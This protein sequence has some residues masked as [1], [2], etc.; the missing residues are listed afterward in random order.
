MITDEK[1]E[2]IPF[3]DGHV[4]ILAEA[5]GLCASDA[6]LEHET[7]VFPK[8]RDDLLPT[9][10]SQGGRVLPHLSNEIDQGGDHGDPADEVTN[11]SER[12]ENAC[13]LPASESALS[14][15]SGHDWGQPGTHSAL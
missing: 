2:E 8:A 3:I 11:V 4:W 13:L 14:M 1:C 5:G 15:P 9:C 10:R 12:L 7:V 6:R